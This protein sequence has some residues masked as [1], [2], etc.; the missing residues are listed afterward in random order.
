VGEEARVVS[1]QSFASQGFGPALSHRLSRW[2][3]DSR[4][5]ATTSGPWGADGIGNDW[6]RAH[7]DGAHRP[8]PAQRG[9]LWGAPMVR[10]PFSRLLRPAPCIRG[11]VAWRHQQRRTAL[12]AAAVA[13]RSADCYRCGLAIDGSRHYL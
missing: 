12:I 8:A 10:L 9:I 13:D 11:F 7:R 2:Q 1:S 6:R 4:N 5:R 3:P